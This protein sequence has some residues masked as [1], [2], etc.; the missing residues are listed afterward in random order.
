MNFDGL[1][2][3]T[4]ERIINA[5]LEFLAALTSGFGPTVGMEKWDAIAESV[6]DNFKHEMFVAML[7]GRSGNKINLRWK[8]NDRGNQFVEFIKKIRIATGWGLKEAKDFADMLTSSVGVVKQI[9]VKS[10][11]RNALIAQFRQIYN[12]EVF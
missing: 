4:H 10:D 1:D 12:L 11:Q 7:S 6:G 8:T 5:G 3:E 2:Q 9:E